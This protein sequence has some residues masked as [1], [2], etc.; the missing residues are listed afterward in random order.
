MVPTHLPS[1]GKHRE[2]GWSSSS[3]QRLPDK[4]AP[5]HNNVRE[6][7]RT[8]PNA[9]FGAVATGYFADLVAVEGDPLFSNIE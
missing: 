8:I 9:I 1:W 2:L 6:S 4:P 7:T 3:R 5:A